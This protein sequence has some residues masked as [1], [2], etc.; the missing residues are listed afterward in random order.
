MQNSLQAI[1]TSVAKRDNIAKLTGKSQ[2]IA[3]FQ[4]DGMI[5]GKILRSTVPHGKIRG[6][7]TEKAK[8]LAGV[9]AVLTHEDVPGSN[10]Y[11]IVFKD[12]PVF[13]DDKVR[14]IGD[15]IAVVGAQTAEIAE[16]ALALIEVDYEILPAVFDVHE[17]LKEDAPQV[18]DKPNLMM[19]R[20]LQKGNVE[21][22]FE[23][24][25]LI[26][27]NTYRTQVV[28]HCYIEPEG[29]V[30][31]YENQT[32]VVQACTQNLHTNRKEIAENLGLPQ[33]HV[34]MVQAVTGGGFGGKLDMHAHIP[35]ALLTYHTKRPAKIVYSREESFA[36]T[37][38]RHP[39]EI[40]YKTGALSDG[41]VKAVC[42]T[43]YMDKGAYTSYGPGVAT[44]AAVHVTGP[45]EVENVDVTVYAVYTNNPRCGAMRGF[46]VPQVAFAHESQMDAIGKKLG[47]S[48][49]AIRLKNALQVGSYTATMQQLEESV[50]IS[51]TLEK[52]YEKAL[53][54]M[55]AGKEALE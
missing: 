47:L 31:Y 53:T 26:V 20:R 46:G 49:I 25:D 27:E 17:A 13:A 16:A 51:E 34:R 18:H 36:A 42:V 8:A 6:I 5:Y 24:C 32:L 33:N 2:Y 30:A 9:V 45:Y 35:A 39:Y 38:K 43:I 11:G 23:T 7:N 50:G 14:Q 19:K 28:D 3:D 41:R 44:R 4:M 29:A 55:E 1:G 12:E 22:A 21:T 48:P 52:A 10:R 15:P 54:V 40:H 37:S